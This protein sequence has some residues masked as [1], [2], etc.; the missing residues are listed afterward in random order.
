MLTL[1]EYLKGDNVDAKNYLEDSVP[2]NDFYDMVKAMPA[3]HGQIDL[4]HF[5]DKE[6]E[7]DMDGEAECFVN[8]LDDFSYKYGAW[9]INDPDKDVVI[10][11]TYNYEGHIQQ[12]IEFTLIHIVDPNSVAYEAKTV[13]FMKVC[14]ASDVRGEYSH[15]GIAIFDE[16]ANII[17]INYNAFAFLGRSFNVA[18]GTVLINGEE[19]DLSLDTTALSDTYSIYLSSNENDSISYEHEI[20]LDLTL[21]NEDLIEE[22]KEITDC[23]D[24]QLVNLSYETYSEN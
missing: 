3:D 7:G 11:N 9:M 20:S 4:K 15:Y 14:I 17:D 23:T 12:A 18:G 2:Y 6:N 22:I 19:F 1:A 8:D 21:D 5:F 16:A 24:V 10:D 13:A